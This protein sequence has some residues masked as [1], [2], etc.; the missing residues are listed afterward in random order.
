MSTTPTNPVGPARST[1]TTQTIRA[2]DLVDSDTVLIEGVWREILD[3]WGPEDD[4]AAEFGEDDPTTL[5][6]EAKTDWSSPCWVAVRF[7]DEDR[8]TDMGIEDALHFFRLRDLVQVQKEIPAIQ[9][10]AH[11]PAQRTTE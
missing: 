1:W 10:T 5:A 3:V 7:I 11:V 9:H 4:P 8:S 6:I 2:T